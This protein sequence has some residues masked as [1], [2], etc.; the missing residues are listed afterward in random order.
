MTS[1]QKSSV[2]NLKM[3][4]FYSV[5]AAAALASLSSAQSFDCTSDIS[6]NDEAT[7]DVNPWFAEIVNTTGNNKYEAV[8][9]TT[10]DG[11]ILNMFRFTGG[12][13]G[14]PIPGHGSPVLL[15]HGEAGDS[16]SWFNG[17]VDAPQV[18]STLFEQG[19][20]VYLSNRRGT[21]ASRTH[22]TLDPDTDAAQY[23][24]F[25]QDEVGK[26]DI[27]AMVSGILKQ[28]LDEGLDCKKV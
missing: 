1:E 6:P 16:T 28:R 14:D 3:K 18:P 11:Y 20:D 22:E 9:V 4:N 19:W 23:W 24:D 26:E 27:P 10:A 25:S 15:V 21:Y 12:P 2:I 5:V 8:E 7:C 17:I 13:D